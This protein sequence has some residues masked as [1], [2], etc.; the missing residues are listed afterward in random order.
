MVAA[1]REV[2]VVFITRLTTEVI[3]EAAIIA[4]ITRLS[5]VLTDAVLFVVTQEAIIAVIRG[6][7]LREDT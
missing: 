1:I 5:D 3:T 4:A 6:A 7:M 2:I